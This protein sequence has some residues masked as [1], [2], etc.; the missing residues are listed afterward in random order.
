MS[1]RQSH[2]PK[3]PTGRQRQIML[4]VAQGFSNKQLARKLCISE[5]TVKVHLH[6][7]FEH[8]GVHKRTALA[9]LVLTQAN[10]QIGS[11]IVKASRRKNGSSTAK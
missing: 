11:A 7:I 5:G 6:N 8:L 3:S 4:L 9:A 10:G 1:D 2:D